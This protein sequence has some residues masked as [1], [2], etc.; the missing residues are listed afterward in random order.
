MIPLKDFISPTH[1]ELNYLYPTNMKTKTILTLALAL[2]TS[3]SL[4]AA[5]VIY[6]GFT[7][8]AADTALAGNAGGTGL[9]GNWTA[10][11]E[12]TVEAT[13]LTHGSLSTSGSATVA[14][15]W[16]SGSPYVG[17]GGTTLNGLTG[18]SGEL[19]MSLLYQAP[20][21]GKIRFTVGIGDTYVTS[22]GYLNPSVT[23]AQAIGFSIPYNTQSAVPVM[24]ETNNYDGGNVQNAPSGLA[25][26][27]GLAIARDGATHMFVLHAEWGADGV[28]NDT[29]TLYTPGTDLVLGSAISTYE[30]IVSQDSFDTLFFSA[31]QSV[32]V[33]DEI[34]VGASY[35]DV[36]PVPEPS[37]F[38]LLA[39]FTGLVWVMLRRRR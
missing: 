1:K 22:N 30:G 10:P 21:T 31:D 9:S 26:G 7:Y 39:G 6:E 36:S 32:G 3:A 14:T 5:A 25:S 18:D 12:S 8:P 28:T 20:T 37:A 34:R 23:D 13:N 4:N 27:S 38:A 2:G 11:S 33:L 35:A 16:N 29:L 19:W 17:I 15:G 24:W